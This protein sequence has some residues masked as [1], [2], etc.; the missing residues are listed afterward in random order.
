MVS[1]SAFT[2][3]TEIMTQKAAI[4][5]Y[6]VAD[7]NLP[8]KVTGFG[9]TFHV[10]VATAVISKAQAIERGLPEALRAIHKNSAQMSEHPTRVSRAINSV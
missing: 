5:P 4:T 6:P 9:S 7:N 3:Y 10:A 1:I 8:I 2:A